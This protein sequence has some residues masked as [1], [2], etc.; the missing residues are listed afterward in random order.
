MVKYFIIVFIFL[1]VVAKG[2]EPITFQVADS[3]T[4]S[5]FLSGNWDKLIDI[6]KQALN[7]NIDY[8]RLRQ[9]MGYAFFAKADYFGAQMHYEKA[10]G[11]D[12][13]DQDTREYLY[14]CGLYTGNS[15][16]ARFNARKLPT[17]L[18]T[19]LGIIRIKPV[20][21]VDLEYNYKSNNSDS[22]TNPTYLRAG[23]STQLGYRF[24]T[25]LSVSNYQ[26]TL[27]SAVT[28]QPEYYAAINWATTAHTSVDL[29]YHYLQTNVN[30]LNI[31]GNLAFLNLTATVN[32][33]IIGINGS[34]LKVGSA[35]TSQLGV[36]GGVT[37][38]GKSNIYLNSMLNDLVE[39]GNSHLVFTQT[40][41]GRVYKSF[42]AEASITLGN[43][44]NYND[45]NALYVYN[46]ID[47]TT[48]RAGG[49]LFYHS[50]LHLTLFGNY[51]YE[52]KQIQNTVS[53]YT[54]QSIS[55]GLIW[56]L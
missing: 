10:L 23:I 11:F 13:F 42:W 43:I 55:G 53:N 38:P 2:K 14:Y 15:A 44:K 29:G 40:A 33:F 12:E 30:G 26:Q 8:K 37:L 9:R 31:P 48:F 39:T 6:G 27:G 36:K 22:R 5:Y 50:G 20:D 21:A 18:K 34:L 32:R 3:L 19:K 56:K 25:Y 54:Q 35:Y 52:T 45:F 17:D 16:N 49:T 47:P 51:S 24:K 1:S 46:S 41:G 4:Y 7:K 28:K